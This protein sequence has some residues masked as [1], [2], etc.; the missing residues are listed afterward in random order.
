[1]H[2]VATASKAPAGVPSD[3]LARRR[4]PEKLPPLGAESVIDT[5]PLLG[6]Y[7]SADARMTNPPVLSPPESEVNHQ[8]GCPMPDLMLSSALGLHVGAPDGYACIR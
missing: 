3:V 8:G 2:D 7:V 1:M 5:V 4:Y 6:S